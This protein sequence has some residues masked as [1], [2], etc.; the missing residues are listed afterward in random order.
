MHR[1]TLIVG[2]VEAT[3]GEFPFIVQL[4]GHDCGGTIL[5]SQWIGMFIHPPQKATKTYSALFSRSITI[6]IY[7]YIFVP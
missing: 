6:M 1:D 5:N 2:G 3:R 7:K 4:K